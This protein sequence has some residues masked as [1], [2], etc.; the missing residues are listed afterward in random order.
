M[1]ISDLEY[2]RNRYYKLK[3]ELNNLCDMLKL[4]MD[5]ID[6]SSIILDNTYLINDN[7]IFNKKYKNMINNLND[8]YNTILDTIIPGI[9]NKI[10]S[11][12]KDINNLTEKKYE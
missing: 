3:E 1:I 4:S 10:E 12:T 11:L 6:D 5:D 9:D 7:N 8:M 2:E